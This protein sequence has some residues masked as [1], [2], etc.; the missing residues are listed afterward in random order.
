MTKTHYTA[1]YT[2]E[3]HIDTTLL[4]EECKILTGSWAGNIEKHGNPDITN[5][6]ISD[7]VEEG[8]DPDGYFDQIG[9]DLSRYIKSP[10]ILAEIFV[11]D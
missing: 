9:R 5:F 11:D 10:V 4:Q 2:I 3:G 8:I 6:T 1:C 7:T